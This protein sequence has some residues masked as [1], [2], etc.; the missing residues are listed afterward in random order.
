MHYIWSIYLGKRLMEIHAGLEAVVGHACV[1]WEHKVEECLQVVHCK[2][3]NISHCCLPAT[4]QAEPGG[5]MLSEHN[6]YNQFTEDACRLCVMCAMIDFARWSARHSSRSVLIFMK[7]KKCC[8][9]AVSAV[10]LLIGIDKQMLLIS[11]FLGRGDRQPHVLLSFT[12][13]L[14]LLGASGRT[15]F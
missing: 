2:V 9:S 3:Y 1:F 15:H 13:L 6:I 7:P 5:C 14:H 11:R 8:T 10:S 4:L 12:M